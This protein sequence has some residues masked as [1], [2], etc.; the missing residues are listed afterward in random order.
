MKVIVDTNVAVVANGRQ[1]Q[2]ASALCLRA[3][4]DAI[5][6]IQRQHTLVL[7]DRWRILKEYQRNLNS[8]GQPGIGDAFLKSALDN[9]TNPL[10]CELTPISS[11]ATSADAADFAEFPEDSRLTTFDRSD[12]KFVAVALAHPEKPPILNATDTDWW[13]HRTTLERYG[14][15]IQFLCP[16]AMA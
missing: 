2:Q 1:V 11:L 15:Q 7:D 3:C 4:I 12:R 9:R 6:D 8:T 10:R 14:V 13:H 5:F 16:D